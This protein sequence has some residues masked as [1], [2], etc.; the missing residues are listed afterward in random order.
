[1]TAIEI[2][3]KPEQPPVPEVHVPVYKVFAEGLTLNVRPVRSTVALVPEVQVSVPIQFAAVN[4]VESPRHT[5][6]LLAVIVG[7]CPKPP[8]AIA[9]EAIPEH[10]PTVQ[11]AV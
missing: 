5:A 9:L 4:V 3:E 10:V 7:V 8:T 6:V 1:V 11:V 2:V